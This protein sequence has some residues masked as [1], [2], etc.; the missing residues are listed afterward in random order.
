MR[1]W[2]WVELLHKAID[3]AEKTPFDFGT[4][5]CGLFAASCIDAIVADSH[6]LD[7]LKSNF[8]DEASARAFVSAAGSMQEAV[9]A[10]LGPS[11][12]WP[13]ARRGDVCL[14]PTQDG[15]GLGVCLG[16]NVAMMAPSGG[17]SYIRTSE[18]LCAWRID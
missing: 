9:A 4:A 12:A 5:N 15:P 18:A 13:L 2:N 17:L 16:L 7:E 10:R 6:R 1:H 8:H 3:A 11:V 14:M